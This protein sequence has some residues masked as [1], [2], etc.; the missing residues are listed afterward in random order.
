M[1]L[2]SNDYNV[3]YSYKPF[4]GSKTLHFYGWWNSYRK[5]YM[6]QHDLNGPIYPADKFI[7]LMQMAEVIKDHSHSTEEI[8]PFHFIDHGG[9]F[10]H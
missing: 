3:H 5:I 2:N 9:E 1:N 4:E 6:Y 8:I 7:N 10:G